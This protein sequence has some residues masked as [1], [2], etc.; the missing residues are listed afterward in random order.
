[1]F[2]GAA[3]AAAVPQALLQY[4]VTSSNAAKAASQADGQQQQQQQ[5]STAPLLQ[6]LHTGEGFDAEQVGGGH[7]V[8][9]GGMWLGAVS[10]WVVATLVVTGS[11]AP[12]A[13]R[14]QPAPV[15]N[16]LPA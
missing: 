13:A 6:Q 9:W 1:M 14:V 7:M 11:L 3:A 12:H 4:A 2:S 8:H 10:S 15:H 16:W 5:D